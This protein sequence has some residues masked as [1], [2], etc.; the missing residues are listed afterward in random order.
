MQ[1]SPQRMQW[2]RAFTIPLSDLDRNEQ[3]FSLGRREEPRSSERGILA[4][5]REI[6]K[7]EIF[8][9]GQAIY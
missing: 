7:Y 4:F 1:H 5:S 2:V 9:K 8:Y 6:K 3:H